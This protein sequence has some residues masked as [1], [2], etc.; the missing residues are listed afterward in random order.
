[1]VEADVHEQGER[2]HLNFGHTLGHAIETVSGHEYAHGEAISL[3]MCA[4]AYIAMKLDLLPEPDR[5]RIARLLS[6]AGLP[7]TGLDLVARH[8]FMERVRQIARDGTTLIL[9]THH[10]EEIVPEIERVLLLRDGRIL[11]SGSKESV[12]TG[13]HLS[14]LFQAPVTVESADGYYYA[15]PGRG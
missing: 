12:M 15:R 6:R 8:A 10:I 4:A 1:M 9:I 13:E 7:T 14:A 2:A 11:V 5:Q 3:G